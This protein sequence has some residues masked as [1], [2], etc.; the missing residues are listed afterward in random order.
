MAEGDLSVVS[1]VLGILSIVFAFLTPAA[2][3]ILGIIGFIQSKKLK[4]SLGRKARKFN[5]IGIIL[6]VIILIISTILIFY[7]IAKGISPAQNFPIF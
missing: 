1:Y 7:S 2:G 5:T 4:T 6:S 3:L